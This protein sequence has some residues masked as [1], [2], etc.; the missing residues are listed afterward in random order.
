[1]HV[2]EDTGAF[3]RTRVQNQTQADTF[4]AWLAGAPAGGAAPVVVAPFPPWANPT[5]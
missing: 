1:V 3:T 4:A 5:C 2:V